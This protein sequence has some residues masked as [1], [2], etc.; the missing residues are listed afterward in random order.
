MNSSQ[1]AQLE[2]A[3][4]ARWSAE[5]ASHRQELARVFADR[6]FDVQAADA[7]WV[8]VNA[9]GLRARLAPHGVVVRDCSSFGMPGTVRVAMPDAKGLERLDD[10]LHRSG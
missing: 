1:N 10:A 6:G 2:N 8:L 9:P 5:I 4:L 3:D 7:P